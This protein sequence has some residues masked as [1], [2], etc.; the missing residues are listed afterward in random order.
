MKEEII[1][2]L[3][4]M[5]INHPPKKK[6]QIKNIIKII[7]EYSAIK[8]KANPYGRIFYIISS[9]LIHLLLL[10]DQKR[11]SICFSLKMI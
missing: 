11:W 10:E 5:V 3:K 8:N 6:L 1:N 7:L 2:Y 9:N 4:K